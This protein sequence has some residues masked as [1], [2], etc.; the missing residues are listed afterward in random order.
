[1]GNKIGFQS[2]YRSS[3]LPIILQTA[4]ECS[5]RTDMRTKKAVGVEIGIAPLTVSNIEAGVSQISMDKAI[6]WCEACRDKLARKAVMHVFGIGRPPTDPRLTRDIGTQLFNYILQL[7]QGI[8]AAKELM[9]I[10]AD[11]R[12][13]IELSK[14]QKQRVAELAEEII[15]TEQ[16]A[17][18]LME[19]IEINIGVRSEDVQNKWTSEAV[20]DQVAVSSIERLINLERERVYG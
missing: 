9:K 12:P 5:I 1:M 4:R 14:G 7:N 20:S 2:I 8:E 16:A 3:A 10:K 19:S 18:C 11:M 13:G 15:D 6:E 17:E